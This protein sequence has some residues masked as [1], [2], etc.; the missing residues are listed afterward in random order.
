MK[1]FVSGALLKLSE[2]NFDVRYEVRR[3][4]EGLSQWSRLIVINRN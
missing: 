4:G 2:L 1:G 3:G